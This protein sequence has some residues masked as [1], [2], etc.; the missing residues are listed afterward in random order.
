MP[1]MNAIEVKNLTRCFGSF[2]AVNDISFS[3]GKGEI[4]GFL[5]ANG[6]GKTTTI[7]ML[8]GI[9]APTSGM[10]SVAGFNIA[11]EA[12]LLKKHIGYMSQRFSLYEDL[13][14]AEN[15]EFFAGIY[16]IN[17]VDI[18][19]RSAW[20]LNMAGLNGKE[21]LI[22]STLSAGWKQ[23]LALGCAVMHK[24]K[25]LFLDEP[26]AGV[27]PISRKQFWDLIYE[28]AASGVTV[29]VTT[30]YMD[31]AE[32]CHRLTLMDRGVIIAE[33]SP[34][35]LKTRVLKGTLFEVEA[36]PF[37]Q[38]NEALKNMDLSYV[39]PFGLKFHFLTPA[40]ASGSNIQESIK[41]RLINA[42]CLVHHIHPI[43]PMLEDVFLALI[44]RKNKEAT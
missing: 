18:K 4:F 14:V 2:C 5:G 7:R 43:K 8:C 24:P 23:R 44:G 22:T 20:V 41:A 29:L 40:E 34:T 21:D 30:H 19:K 35:D 38:V 28:M 6:A 12:D 32:H 17:R 33:G 39:E 37:S 15:I 31:E 3:V 25:V 13:T 36:E 26:T 11:M 1:A 27:D 16:G 9:L 10:A 42:R